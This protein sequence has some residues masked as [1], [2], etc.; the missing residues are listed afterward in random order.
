MSVFP[1]PP[2]VSDNLPQRMFAV[3]V[4]IVDAEVHHPHPFGN[5]IE[6][7]PSLLV[8]GDNHHFPSEPL[9]HPPYL[10]EHHP[11]HPARVIDRVVAIDDFHN[12]L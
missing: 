5:G 4:G 2:Q 11:L 6:W 7:W 10:V 1:P 12:E 8:G 9:H 3:V